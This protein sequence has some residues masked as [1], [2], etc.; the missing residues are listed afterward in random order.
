MHRKTLLVIDMLNDFLDPRGVLYCGEEARKIIPA[1][2]RLMERFQALGHPVI[3]LKDAHAPDDKEFALFAPHAVRETWGAMVIP[4]LASSPASAVIEKTRF[5]GFFGNNLA[6]VLAETQP[7][8]VWVTGVVTSIC[9][10]DTAGDLCNRDYPVVIP[11]DGVAD[12]DAEFH[13]FALKRMERV[14]GARFILS[15]EA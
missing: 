12:F 15:A 6:E 8:E 14:Y 5:S 7:D 9:V 2:K 13:A 4:E 11:L 10:M 1:V 3:V